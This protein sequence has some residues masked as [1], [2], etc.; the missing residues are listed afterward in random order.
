MLKFLHRNR[1]YYYFNDSGIL[2]RST[3]YEAGD[4]LHYADA[5]GAFV[6]EGLREIDGKI[7]YFHESTATKKELRLEDKDITLHF[8]D[9]GVL[10]KAS[11]LNGEA[12]SSQEHVTFN[13]KKLVFEKDGSIRKN[14][15]SKIF[16]PG[17]NLDGKEQP[18]LVYYSLEE[19]SNYSG[20][21][22]IEGKK[23]YFDGGIHYTF[24]GHQEIKGKRYYFNQDGEAKLTGF[25]KVD[26]K[27]Y[28][29]DD[30]GVMQ[31]G[32]KEINGKW[33]YFKESGEAAIGKFSVYGYFAPYYGYFNYY[34]KE[35]GSIYRNE[36]VRLPSKYGFK[37][38]VFDH[39]GHYEVNWNN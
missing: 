22:E 19:G 15:V 18:A 10:E 28:Y 30:K 36:T 5:S 16:L 1:K 24:D 34:A 23:Y 6:E 33:Y 39:N 7:Y 9:K 11:K 35:D 12:L 26:G 29:Y 37:D 31:T 38:V 3:F 2:Q 21:K 27:I 32:W 4:Y 20:W 17:L 13:E 25:D 8:S 14:G